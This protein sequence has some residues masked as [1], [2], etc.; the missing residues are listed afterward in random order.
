M[1][2]FLTANRSQYAVCLLNFLNPEELLAHRTL[3]SKI[4]TI[5]ILIFLSL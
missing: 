2:L 1:I 5:K 4:K 3:Y